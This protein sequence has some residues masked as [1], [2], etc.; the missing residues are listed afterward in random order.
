MHSVIIS[1]TSCL[2]LLSN[3]GMPEILHQLFGTIIT[4]R[5]VA[6]EYGNI[7]YPIG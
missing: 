4:T 5:D 2:I 7:L 3:I 6:N 1:D